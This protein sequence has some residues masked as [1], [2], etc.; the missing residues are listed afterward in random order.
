MDFMHVSFTLTFTESLG[1]N[2]VILAP[3]S[4]KVIVIFRENQ[5]K[6]SSD[7]VTVINIYINYQ[8]D[9]TSCNDGG[10]VWRTKN[11]ASYVMDKISKTNL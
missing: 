4:G 11:L 1:L 8:I 7:M 6:F 3:V 5:I 10:S 9:A 2:D